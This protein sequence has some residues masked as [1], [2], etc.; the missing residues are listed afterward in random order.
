MSCKGECMLV[1]HFWRW[2]EKISKIW[3]RRKICESCHIICFS[4]FD[5][6]GRDTKLELRDDVLLSY[7][8]VKNSDKHV[9]EYLS[10]FVIPRINYLWMETLDV[11]LIIHNS[12][13]LTTVIHRKVVLTED[14]LAI[15]ALKLGL[16][17]L[18]DVCKKQ[19]SQSISVSNSYLTRGQHRQQYFEDDFC[20]FPL[21][22][23]GYPAKRAGSRGRDGPFGRIP[24]ICVTLGHWLLIST[25]ISN[26]IPYNESDEIP[27]NAGIKV[28]S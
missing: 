27:I 22:Y 25:W 13:V 9:Y 2:Y 28:D 16:H 3:C 18:N 20:F 21:K 8:D 15:L 23:R 19:L 4:F 6:R 7:M 5:G 24:A 14:W 1:Q 17:L 10:P 11:L 26:Y 12:L